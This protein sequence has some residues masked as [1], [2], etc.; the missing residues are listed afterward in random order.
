MLAHKG[1]A[2]LQLNGCKGGHGPLKGGYISGAQERGPGRM[3]EPLI[4]NAGIARRKNS[5][6]GRAFPNYRRDHWYCRGVDHHQ[7]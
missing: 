6:K 7:C 4:P 3:G 1:Q 5:Q 2:L